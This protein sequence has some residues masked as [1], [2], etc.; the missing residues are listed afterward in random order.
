VAVSATATGRGANRLL[1]AAVHHN[2][3]ENFY[4]VEA[5]GLRREERAALFDSGTH[6]RVL[7]LRVGY[8]GTIALEQDL[9]EAAFIVK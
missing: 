4:A 5:I 7:I 3:P 6:E 9:I 1:V 8:R 2:D